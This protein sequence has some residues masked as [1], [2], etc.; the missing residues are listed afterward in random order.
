LVLARIL[1]AEALGTRVVV[2]F[3]E[4]MR[5]RDEMGVVPEELIEVGEAAL[6]VGVLFAGVVGESGAGDLS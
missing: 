1:A 2:S 5:G 3:A 6:A 4:E